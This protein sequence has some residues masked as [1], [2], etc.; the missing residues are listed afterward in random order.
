MR[1]ELDSPSQT[2]LCVANIEKGQ[3]NEQ[4]ATTTKSIQS[5]Q[6]GFRRFYTSE[7]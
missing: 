2:E 4:P 5:R 3:T 7:L 1:Y 6:C